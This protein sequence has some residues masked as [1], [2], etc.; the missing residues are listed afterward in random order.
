MK[1]YFVSLAV[2]IPANF[3]VEVSASSEQDAFIKAQ[4]MFEGYDEK[5]ISEPSWQET[6]LDIDNENIHKIGNG[7]YIERT[8]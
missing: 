1:K 4:D 5:Y 2:K 7:I 3:E 6:D 8:N